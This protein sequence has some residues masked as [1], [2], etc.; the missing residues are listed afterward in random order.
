MIS[1]VAP[2]E[3][4]PFTKDGDPIDIILSPLGVPARKNLGQILEMHLGLAAHALDYQAIVPSMTS[5]TD[6]EL[7]EEL[8]K[9]GYPETG[10]IEL[11][12]GKTGEKFDN[13]VSVGWMYIMKLEHMVQDKIH[14]RS[15]GRYS[16]ITQ[17]PP[18]GRSRFGANR[19]GEM[20]VWALLGHGASHT[21]RE[22]LTIKSDDMQG[23]NAAY[24]SIVHSEPITHVG[25][26]ATFNVLL[27]YLRGLGLNVNLETSDKPDTLSYDSPRRDKESGGRAGF[28]GKY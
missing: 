12:D 25:V 15:T 19:L 27:Y 22:T 4:M 3:D 18:G 9:A 7:R 17:Q 14:A 11:F 16:L 2:I 28:R 8:R 13:D 10:Q 26:P 24:R 21:L 20:E 1:R 6:E 23:R 5:V